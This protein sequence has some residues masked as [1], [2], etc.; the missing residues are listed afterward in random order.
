M[1]STFNIFKN[2]FLN[3]IDIKDKGHAKQL[4]SEFQFYNDNKR[5]PISLYGLTPQG[6]FDGEIIDKYKFRNEIRQTAK[7]RYLK[8]KVED[9]AMYVP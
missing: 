6:V 9:F 4:L 2:E 1:E 3:N 5:Y 7:Q 8:N